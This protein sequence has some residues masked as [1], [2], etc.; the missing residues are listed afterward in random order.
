MPSQRIVFSSQYQYQIEEPYLTGCLGAAVMD[1]LD[2]QEVEAGIATGAGVPPA[3][4]PVSTFVLP[5][6]SLPNI[7]IILFCAVCKYQCLIFNKYQNIITTCIGYYNN[8]L[9]FSTVN[10]LGVTENI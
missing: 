9:F 1:I 4:A 10:N 5:S 3:G 8:F 6:N 7:T 2:C